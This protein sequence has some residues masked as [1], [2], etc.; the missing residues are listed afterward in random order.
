MPGRIRRC[1]SRAATVT[2]LETGGTL[3]G[4]FPQAVFEPG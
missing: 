4:A 3:I 1:C 2:R